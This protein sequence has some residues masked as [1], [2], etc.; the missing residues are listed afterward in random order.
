MGSE[1]Q[2]WGGGASGACYGEV[3]VDMGDGEERATPL[4]VT[5][6]QT[7]FTDLLEVIDCS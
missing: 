1:F 2:T 4:R 7:H 3:S 5:A 6:C